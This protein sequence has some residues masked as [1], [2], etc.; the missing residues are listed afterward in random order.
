MMLFKTCLAGF[1][2][3]IRKSAGLRDQSVF[4]PF[5]LRGQIRPLRR[6]FVGTRRRDLRKPRPILDF[7]DTAL[8]ETEERCNIVVAVAPLDHAPNKRNVALVVDAFA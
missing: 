5:H 8:I 1:G 7:S 6:Q 3:G 2:P 4:H